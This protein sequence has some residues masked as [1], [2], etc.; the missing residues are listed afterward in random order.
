V[1]TA[2][3]ILPEDE[4]AAAAGLPVARGVCVDERLLTADPAVSAIGDCARFP[5]RFSEAPVLLESVQNAVEQGRAAAA[6][7]A[8][9][10]EPY[11]VVPWFWSDQ[12]G[13]R[14]QIAGLTAGW[15]DAVVLGEPE[16]GKFS[17][18]C[19]AG[20]RLRGVESVGRP[21]DHV[22]ARRLLERPDAL[23]PAAARSAD[24]DLK[25]YAR[26]A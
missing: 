1:L 23:S 22:A 13:V 7:I 16:T 11:E 2:V 9:R 15:D 18:L 6:R 20:G 5:C 25:T 17:T 19:F 4:L 26:A 10:G 24:F 21:G 12:A 8:G 14:L 3:G